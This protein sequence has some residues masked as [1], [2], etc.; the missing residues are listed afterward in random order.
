MDECDNPVVVT[1]AAQHGH[2]EGY[3]KQQ[4]QQQQ[5]QK[6]KQQSPT[7]D[8]KGQAESKKHGSKSNRRNLNGNGN[9]NGNG[10]GNGNNWD[11]SQEQQPLHTKGT[12]MSFGF[13]KKLNGTPK[14][15]KK[16]LE[17]HTTSTPMTDTK[18]DNGNAATTP[19]HFEKVGAAAAPKSSTA[20]VAA[21]GAAG[22]R[23]G[24]RG[25]LPRP[26]STGLYGGPSE[27]S[28]S[29]T[30]AQNTQN[31][32][33]HCG[34]GG[35]G[36]AGTSTGLVSNLKRRSKSAHAGRS[37]GDGEQPKIAQPKTLT[38]NLN[39]NTTIEYQRRQFFGEIADETTAAAPTARGGQQ[40][41]NYNNLASMHANVIVRPTPRLTLASF[42]KFTL[43]D[44]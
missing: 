10:N 20:G 35:G 37:S 16:L 17:S 31:N 24:Y 11:S 6:Q 13:R 27:E 39:Q 21:A 15:F 2:G 23:F 14:K 26:A 40:R 19:I 43:A 22:K 25:A 1:L 9:V 28:E 7:I 12:A 29:E 41:Y 4:Q 34:G 32:N 36:V 18:D 5:Q 38:F 8:D 33:N 44:G 30:A 42:A 3:E